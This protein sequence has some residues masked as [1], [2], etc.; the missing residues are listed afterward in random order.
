MFVLAG[1]KNFFFFFK[2]AK[3]LKITNNEKKLAQGC[4]KSSSNS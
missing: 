3:S 2:L 4:I 1:G